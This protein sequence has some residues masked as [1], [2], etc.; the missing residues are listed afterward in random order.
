V[1]RL[2]H[3]ELEAIDDPHVRH[4]RLVELNVEEQVYHLSATS[5]IQKAWPDKVVEH[6]HGWVYDI[7]EGLLRD[8]Q[9]DPRHRSDLDVYS[10]GGTSTTA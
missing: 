1:Y 6:I 8:L 4:R 5:I 7:R 9:V 3:E 10:L 2:H